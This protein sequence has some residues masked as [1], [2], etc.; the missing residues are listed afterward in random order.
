MFATLTGKFKLPLTSLH[1]ENSI[2]KT[3]VLPSLVDITADAIASAISSTF[4]I[5][6]VSHFLEKV[7]F[8]IGT[9]EGNRTPICGFG[10]RHVTVTPHPY[11]VAVE[12][13]EPTLA[14]LETGV[15]PL[16]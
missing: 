2:L 12:G 4:S 7:K 3:P 14:V 6:I 10:D 9:D 8:L 1:L 16:H 5:I 15:L 11:L 13:F